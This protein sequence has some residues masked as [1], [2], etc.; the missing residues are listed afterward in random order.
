MATPSSDLASP[1]TAGLLAQPAADSWLA[2]VCIDACVGG[3]WPILAAPG[4]PHPC[5]TPDVVQETENRVNI[6]VVE[7]LA[8]A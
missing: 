4:F 5:I 2:R 7:V 3:P 8:S 6:E 1:S